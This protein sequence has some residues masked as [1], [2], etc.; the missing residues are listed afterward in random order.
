M[1]E[2]VDPTEAVLGRNGDARALVERL[3]VVLDV[4][5]QRGAE[6][7]G[8]G[9]AGGLPGALPRLGKHGKQNRSQDRNDGDHH[10]QLDQGKRGAFVG[11]GGVAAFAGHEACAGTA[12]E[13]TTLSHSGFL[14]EP[15]A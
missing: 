6:L 9:K 14:R 5:H 1:A 13:T 11:D 8:V 4:H 10:E 3:I 2:I 12:G 15:A 7:A